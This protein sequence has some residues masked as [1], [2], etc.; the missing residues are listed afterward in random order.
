MGVS[1]AQP[2]GTMTL[3]SR[4]RARVRGWA[5]S[6][7]H[8]TGGAR[9]AKAVGW[10]EAGRRR[11]IAGAEVGRGER[12]V[13]RMAGSGG[14]GGPAW[15]QNRERPWRRERREGTGLMAT[16]GGGGGR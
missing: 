1:R 7:K 6:A 10:G 11:P 15:G 2:D 9:G 13:T 3:Q 8:G 5:L 14:A 4:P 16:T 12:A